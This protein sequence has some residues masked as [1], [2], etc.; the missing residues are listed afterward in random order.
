MLGLR[1]AAVEEVKRK[2]DLAALPKIRLETYHEGLSAQIMHV[3]PFSEEPATIARLHDFITQQ[4]YTIYRK[5]HEIYLS[6][7]RRTAPEKLKTIIR[8]PITKQA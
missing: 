3:G 1:R 6:D 2:K 5:H 4:G 7:F 8:Y